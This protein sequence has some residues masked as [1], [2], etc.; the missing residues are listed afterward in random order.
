M[1]NLRLSAFETTLLRMPD[2]QIIRIISFWGLADIVACDSAS[3]VWNAD[4]FFAG[5]FKDHPISFRRV[6][7]E[8]G[9][10]VSGSQVTQFFD[11]SRYHDSDMDIF[12]HIGGITHM[13][14]WLQ[15]QGYSYSSMATEYDALKPDVLRL[16]CRM[17]IERNSTD[18][19][20]K[21]VFNYI[22][23]IPST[24]TAFIQKIQLIVVDISPIDHII[25]DFHSSAMIN[26][27]TESE[28]VCVFP[29]PTLILHKSYVV[30]SR[31]ESL[32]RTVTWKTKYHERGFQIIRKRTKGVHSD[33]VLGKRSSS[34]GRAWCMK[35]QEP[36][37]KNTVYERK[38]GNVKFE[39]LSWRSGVTLKDSFARIAEP[40]IWRRVY[41]SMKSFRLP[42]GIKTDCDPRQSRNTQASCSPRAM[43]H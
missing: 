8:C 26:Y 21:G 30:R 37:I 15:T 27:M 10:I 2:E 29:I 28:I 25:F 3:V 19:T 33:L 40:G 39:I 42:D 5:W 7:G 14:D 22:R 12:M 13:G 1:H 36:E 4:R 43:T 17:L 11:R 24:T 9:G 16:S 6:L 35:L 20:I 41:L 31:T 18:E 23:Y 34:D 38:P 32:S